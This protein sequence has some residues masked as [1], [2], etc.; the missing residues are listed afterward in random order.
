L[1]AKALLGLDG[2]QVFA[3]ELHIVLS[4]A[5]DQDKKII[6][7]YKGYKRRNLQPDQNFLQNIAYTRISTTFLQTF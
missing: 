2:R 1:K 4:F 3:V 6:D 7:C 5:E